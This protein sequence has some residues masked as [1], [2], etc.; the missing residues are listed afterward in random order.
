MIKN[1]NRKTKRGVVFALILLTVMGTVFLSEAKEKKKT[2][3]ANGKKEVSQILHNVKGDHCNIVGKNIIISGNAYI[4]YGKFIVYADKATFNIENKDLKAF[5]NVRVHVLDGKQEKNK[6]FKAKSVTGNLASGY[7]KFVDFTNR[8]ENAILKAD[9]CILNPDGK[10]TVENGKLVTTKKAEKLSIRQKL[11]SII[12]PSLDL[13][14]ATVKTAVQFLNRL[15]KRYDPNGVGVNI[16]LMVSDSDLKKPVDLVLK[17][18][19]LYDAIYFLC[20]AS[21]L[22]FRIQKNLVLIADKTIVHDGFETKTFQLKPG[23]LAAAGVDNS[24]GIKKYFEDRGVKFP[25]GAELFYAR[26]K[27]PFF[28]MKNTRDN[29]NRVESIVQN[30]LN[31]TKHSK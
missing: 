21:G 9:S 20:K 14:S 27:T 19:S 5:G 4:P 12:I 13:E 29:I 2:I 15:G 1:R 24:A 3:E 18:K 7:L 17:K 31:K 10:I 23:A 30:E 6:I 8:Q 16:I 11:K 28:I 26:Q 25:A 22:R